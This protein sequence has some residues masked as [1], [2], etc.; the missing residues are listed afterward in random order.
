[1]STV[2][3]GVT[4]LL[5]PALSPLMAQS[6]LLPREQ[7]VDELMSRMTTEE[8]IGQLNLLDGGSINTGNGP[9]GTEV[10]QVKAGNVGG[11]F[12]L[13]G[14]ERIRAVQQ[15]AVEQSRLG[16]PLIFG[17]DVIHGYR[18]IFPIPL[19]LSCSWDTTLVRRAAELSAMECSADGIAW[20]FSPMVDVSKDARWGR[21]AEGA[22]EDPFLGSAMAGAM[23][24]GYQQN[25]GKGTGVMACVKHFALYGA[26]EAGLDY[27]VTDMSRLRM[28]N[29]YMAPYRAA[30]E[31][32]VGSVM[33]SFNTVDLEPATLSHW[34][35]TELLR[36]QWG[37]E[38]FVVTDYNS[39]K[40]AEIWGA[41]TMAECAE[42]AL[43]A[44]TDMDMC[45]RAYVRHLTKGLN[46]GRIGVE[47]IN[48]ACR[49]I[50]LA[51]Y[52][53]G[54][55]ADPYR[56]CQCERQKEIRSESVKA[57]ARKIAPQT[58][59]LLKNE[60]DILPL[61]ATSRIALVGPL[62]DA[63]NNTYGMWAPSADT[64]NEVFATLRVALAQSLGKRGKLTYAMGSNIQPEANRN[65]FA[66][67]GRTDLWNPTYPEQMIAEAVAA[68]QKAD[69]VV[70]AVGE[71]QEMTGEATS[72]TLLDLPENQQALLRALKATGKP[73]VVVYYTGRP[74]VMGWEKENADALLNV[75]FPGSE[76]NEAIADVLLGRAEPTGRLTTSFPRQSGMEPY[77]YNR[78]NTGRPI[79]SEKWFVKYCTNYQDVPL[80]PVYPFGYG[81][82][83]TTFEYS[84][85]GLSASEMALDGTVTAHVTVRNTGKRSG[86]EVVQMYIRD[87]QASVLRPIKELKGFRKIELAPGESQTV[88]FRIDADLL[89]FYNRDLKRVCEPGLF[90][91]M[92][93]P[94]CERVTSVDLIVK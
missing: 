63:R 54:L 78:Y 43:Q 9:K 64:A 69:V 50:L 20:T 6:P 66:T 23:V 44:G 79:S 75:W 58:M 37:F 21:I 65:S 49:R 7:F 72:R 73:L 26:S 41:G 4:L 25:I 35:L 39:I 18:T 52:D 14:Q 80:D 45:S 81:L 94:D 29:E 90:K 33:S 67:W 10:E 56:Y 88:E 92:I 19:A 22:G 47:Q 85:V 17:L 61:S 77:F 38:G 46:D 32:G 5:S 91:I 30:V 27:N 36:E 15:V 68:A 24:R 51:K 31:A 2:L 34:L 28:L 57:E 70:A 59:V 71:G 76:G 82:S 74:V 84:N 55:F 13:L 86:H 12:G 53:L 8:K 93:G 60:G 40:E 16:I 89:S 87:V 62:A 3:V 11:L 42:R 83:Y 48:K 1:M